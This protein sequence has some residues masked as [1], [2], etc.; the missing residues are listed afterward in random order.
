MKEVNLGMLFLMLI[1]WTCPLSWDE[2]PLWL[3]WLC[4]A[5]AAFLGV[6]AI[7]LSARVAIYARGESW[8]ARLAKK[9]R[10]KEFPAFASKRSRGK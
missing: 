9:F 10:E 8:S 6:R 2:V 5:D 3:R 1:L 7:V 4:I